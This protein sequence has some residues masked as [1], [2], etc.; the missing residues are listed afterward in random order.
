MDQ[1]DYRLPNI[2]SQKQTLANESKK[3]PRANRQ[4]DKFL[5]G[6]IPW[7][8]LMRALQ[9]GGKVP[10]VIVVIW[11]FVGVKKSNTFPLST[12]ILKRELGVGRG[13]VYR[14]LSRLEDAKLLRVTRR[15]GRLAIVEVIREN[16]DD[17]E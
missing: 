13:S 5:R 8:W 9:L 1:K 4:V 16:V 6:P 11:F 7:W 15:R 14:A 3:S 10:Q 12:R 2:S 17:E